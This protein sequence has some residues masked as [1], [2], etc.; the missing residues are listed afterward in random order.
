MIHTALAN[1]PMLWSLNR[2]IRIVKNS[3]KY[4]M[5]KK[6]QSIWMMNVPKSGAIVVLS[7]WVGA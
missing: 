4:M 2:S 5:M 1:P 3:M 6:I 7:S